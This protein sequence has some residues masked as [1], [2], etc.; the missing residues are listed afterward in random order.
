MFLLFNLIFNLYEHFIFDQKDYK[1][2]FNFTKRWG[3]S[4]IWDKQKKVK[5]FF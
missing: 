3:C 2:L 1:E 5:F 4:S